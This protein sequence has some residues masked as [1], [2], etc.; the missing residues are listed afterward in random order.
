MNWWSTSDSS[1]ESTERTSEQ[2]VSDGGEVKDGA[3]TNHGKSREEL[4][5]EVERL[6]TER[7]ETVTE[8]E[9]LES[10]L[11]EERE[12]R[13]RMREAV[14][15]LTAVVSANADGD[16]RTTPGETTATSVR[17]LY[18]AY[19]ELLSEWAETVDRMASFSEQVSS[20]TEQVDSQIETVKAA[21]R[22]VSDT[23]D[24][25]SDGSEQQNDWIQ[26]ISA[27]MNSL[28]A[29]VQQIAD[30]ADQAAEISDVAADR[31]SVA[32]DSA[33]DAMAEL[34]RLTEHAEET[35]E[36]V[37]Q[38]D[39]LMGEIEDIVAFI[40]QV[41]D[42]TNILALNANIE[43]ARAG[44][45]GEGFSVVASEVKELA[46]E[47]KEATA[48][49][50]RSIELVQDQAERTVEEMH[51]TRESVADTRE[52]VSTAAEEL[53][54]IAEK[55]TEIDR[56][57][58][59]IDG[60]TETQAD[61][62]Q[63]VVSKIDEVSEISDSTAQKAAV[64][65]DAAQQQTTQLVEVSTRVSTLAERAETLEG[66][67]DRFELS[68]SR[69]VSRSEDT[70][71]E[72][73]HAMGGEKALL[74]EALASEFEE[75]ADGISISLTSKGSY[76][77]TLDAT[78]SAAADGNPPAIAQIF[79]IGS[80]RARD[81]TAFVPVDRLLSDSHIDSLLDPVTDYYRFDGELHSVPF[82]A[83]NPILAYNR[84]AFEQ[85]GLDPNAPP[86]TFEEVIEASETLVE[87]GP[88][89]YGIT[90]ANYS[91][92]VEQ[93]FSEA[94]ELLVDGENGRRAPPTTTNLD[95]E[96]G[97][98][99]F[100]WWTDIEERDLY[101]DPGI[102][103]RGAAKNAFHDREAAM[104]IG[105]TSSLNS[106]ESGA[107]FGVGTG[108]FPVLDERAGVLVGG[109]SLWVGESLP[110]AVHEAAAEFLTWL[111]EPPQQKRWH[112]ET[113]YFPVQE[114]AIP[115]LREEGWFD[116]NPHYETAFDQLVE[117][118]DTMAT[119]GAQ[120]GPFDTVRSIIEE[121]FESIDSVE[122][123]PEE[124]ARIDQQVEATLDSYDSGR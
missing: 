102:E 61:Y 23:V 4:Q 64:V 58:Q 41:A 70:V 32:Q 7:E 31:G 106:I 46:S 5:A 14:D 1:E 100:E 36:N 111:T 108:K 33:T 112:R 121:G 57:V 73:W 18:D 122:T 78:I 85:A 71:V 101:C 63:D 29:T 74:L 54:S 68:D 19:G 105:S 24:V 6:R 45:A 42:Q 95:G 88:T 44:E 62:A 66:T 67:L 93:W 87:E 52:T 69:T 25:I 110:T 113:G 75:V 60:A 28:S 116:Q 43:A 86:E 109:A 107:E 89:E 53:D 34:D 92:F 76:R 81:S 94:D 83:S 10:K 3:A 114:R 13:E 11:A 98:T 97:R 79:E 9:H 77:G 84:D 15:E 16:L 56:T 96:F 91:W 103:A 39:D 82:N 21:S 124:L 37:E 47:T 115:Q 120:I 117:K 104:L 50:E 35:V 30:L 17:P 40:T 55:V 38:L 65:A 51:R 26:D 72:F 90:F 20:A 49:A 123:V 22:D 80:T 2:P 119:R 118:R 27:E 99:L 59:E 8:A 48:E 12:Q